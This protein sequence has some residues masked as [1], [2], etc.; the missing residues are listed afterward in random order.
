MW[1]HRL[2]FLCFTIRSVAGFAMPGPVWV[3][4]KRRIPLLEDSMAKRLIGLVAFVCIVGVGFRPISAG[5]SAGGGEFDQLRHDRND[6]L[7]HPG[8]Y[9][10]GHDLIL[11]RQ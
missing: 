3:D 7:H 11:K 9:Y 10:S 1:V 4:R 2:P 6:G 8:P 5:P